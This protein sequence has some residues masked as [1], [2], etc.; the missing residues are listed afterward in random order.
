MFQLTYHAVQFNNT[1]ENFKSSIQIGQMEVYLLE[2]LVV[3]GLLVIKSTS[4]QT[5]AERTSQDWPAQPSTS[6]FRPSFP[7]L[8]ESVLHKSC[9]LKVVGLLDCK[10]ELLKLFPAPHHG[11]SV[12]SPRRWSTA[13]AD[14]TKFR[15]CCQ[16][17]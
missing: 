15:F 5:L 8:V 3:M 16:P 14:D 7:T 6:V 17:A 12:P 2:S 11:L 13:K 4:L 1:A 10:E 9:F